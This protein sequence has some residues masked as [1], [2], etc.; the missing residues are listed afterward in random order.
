MKKKK[1]QAEINA[2]QGKLE[3]LRAKHAHWHPAD[4]A[5]MHAM[6]KTIDNMKSRMALLENPI[7]KKWL[8]YCMRGMQEIDNVLL[9]DKELCERER[10]VLMEKREMLKASLEIFM[11]KERVVE[12]L[13]GDLDDFLKDGRSAASGFPQH[14]K[15]Y[16]AERG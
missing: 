12:L 11:P 3:K 2:A 15:T 1:L 8:S 7:A 6:Q 5:T 9:N 4:R 14:S 13:S 16:G 10:R